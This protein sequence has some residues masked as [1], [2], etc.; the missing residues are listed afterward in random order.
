MVSPYSSILSVCLFLLSIF[1]P[2]FYTI[3]FFLFCV[4]SWHCIS[5]INDET[6][7]HRLYP[8]F[9][10]FKPV[11]TLFS[12]TSMLRKRVKNAELL[13]ERQ[14]TLAIM[15]NKE[16]WKCLLLILFSFLLWR[17]RRATYGPERTSKGLCYYL[18]CACWLTDSSL[19]SAFGQK[20]QVLIGWC[21]TLPSPPNKPLHIY[22]H[23]HGNSV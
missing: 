12:R 7:N 3:F 4:C 23:A 2:L 15:A 21:L 11:S 17:G 1:P 10:E 5:P 6:T 16:T 13:F 14:R 20:M 8:K 18:A 22:K 9:K 19:C